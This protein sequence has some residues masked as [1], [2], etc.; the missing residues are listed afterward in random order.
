MYDDVVTDVCRELADRIAAIVDAG[1]DV[2]QL[3]IDPGIGFAKRPDADDNWA[4]LRHLDRLID[5]GR[6]VLIGASRKAFL[7]HLLAADGEP[8]PAALRDQASGAVTALVAA[9]GAWAVRVHD[10]ARARRRG[11]GGRPMAGD[12]V[13]ASTDG[14]AGSPSDRIALRGLTVRG[15]HGVF[16]HERANG[17]DFVVDVVLELDTSVAASTDALA[18]TVDY[19]ALAHTVA[20]IVAASRCSC[21][22]RWPTASRPRVLT[23]CASFGLR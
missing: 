16:D 7:G 9:A 12:A 13:T 1:V 17:Q 10:V 15:R 4:L 20:A 3:I 11:A 6:P 8:R 22:R 19:G 21:S 23:M 5:L 14:A 2:N 18:D